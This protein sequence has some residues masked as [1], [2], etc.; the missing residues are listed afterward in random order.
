MERFKELNKRV[1]NWADSR[2]IL[3]KATPLAQIEK[4]LEEVNE[5][6]E[7]LFAKHN[8][9]GVYINSKG[10]TKD[11]EEEI[12]DGFGDVFVTILIGCKL[13]NINPLDAIESALEIIE[14]RKGKMIDGKFV[15][16]K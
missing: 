4:T 13:E 16:E 8:N 5:T 11:S 7:A 2:G 15:K 12:L 6:R 10:E 14:K 3:E 1:I 9:L